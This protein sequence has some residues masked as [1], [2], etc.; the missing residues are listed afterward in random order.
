MSTTPL[1]LATERY[2]MDLHDFTRCSW[3]SS[4]LRATWQPRIQRIAHMLGELEWLALTS[5][6]RRCAL[7]LIPEYSLAEASRNLEQNGLQ[8]H[9]LART[10]IAGTYRASLQPPSSAGQHAVWTAAADPASLHDFVA[11]YHARDEERVGEL[12][13]YPNCCSVSFAERWQR[14]GL[15]DT[16]WPMAVATRQKRVVSPRHVIIPSATEAGV[17]LRWLGVRAVFHLP[18]SFD[19]AQSAALAAEHRALAEQHGFALEWRWLA[20]LQQQPCEWTALHGI[21]ELKTPLFKIAARTDATLRKYTVQY[22]GRAS[23]TGAPCGLS[24]PFQTPISLKVIG[25]ETYKAG[26]RNPIS[27][28]S[29]DPVEQSEWYHR[30]N[31]FSTHYA[32]SKSHAALVR[33]A[34]EYLA[35][36]DGNRVSHVLDLGCGNGALLRTLLR[37]YPSLAPAGIDISEQKIDHARSLHPAHV[38]NFM[39]GN[40][41]DIT[42]LTRL[43]PSPLVLLMIGRL[44]EAAPEQAKTLLA[45]MQQQH[46]HVLL[47]AYDDYIRGK[48]PF[49]ALAAKIGVSLSRFREGLFVTTAML[50]V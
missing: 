37:A 31:G 49:A 29:Y 22:E 47:Y 2:D 10:S 46:A 7:K 28:T 40:L 39:T 1:A 24:F 48:E 32:M 12:L 50:Q 44:T 38:S 25:S 30:D 34:V 19:C 43:P 36:N 18:C 8:L 27:C 26:L 4:D 13:G 42:L 5:G 16:T 11:A 15:I 21:A 9:V 33:S 3:T 41:F 45:A 6:L 35:A 14:Q 20:E 17:H 23:S